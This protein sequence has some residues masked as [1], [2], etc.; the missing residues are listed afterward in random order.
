MCIILSLNRR[1]D[2]FLSTSHFNIIL[3][4]S[5]IF[6]ITFFFEIIFLPFIEASKLEDGRIVII[7]NSILSLE[8]SVKKQT[9]SS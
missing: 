3:I 9:Y 5:I 8:D 2:I 1:V 4:S 6:E 7:E